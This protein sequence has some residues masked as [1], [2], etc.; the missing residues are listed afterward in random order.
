M[1]K[2]FNFPPESS[3]TTG[4]ESTAMLVVSHVTA[5]WS[6]PLTATSLLTLVTVA[7]R[8]KLSAG[9]ALDPSCESGPTFR[10]SGR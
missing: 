5:L 3:A 4:V 2:T 6:G 10:A 9:L 8:A 7:S 1:Q